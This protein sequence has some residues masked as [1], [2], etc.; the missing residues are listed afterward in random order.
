MATIEENCK[1][2]AALVAGI[3]K[4]HHLTENTVL[5]I[6]DMNFALAQ[7]AQMPSFGGSE[8][9]PVGE[10]DEPIIF[11]TV[12]QIPMFAEEDLAP[13]AEEDVL[14]TVEHK[15]LEN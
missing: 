7:A 13:D 1:S 11:P 6:I 15:E 14:A 12:E 4:E 10:A 2:M 8:E 5:R 9:I 3:K